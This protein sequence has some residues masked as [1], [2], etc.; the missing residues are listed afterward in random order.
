[1]NRLGLLLFVFTSVAAARHD[2]AVCGTTRETTPEALFRHR[3]SGRQF[4]PRAITQPA[5]RDIGNVAVIEDSGGVVEKLNQF[6]LDNSTVTFT[7][8]L[9]DASR[10]R[11]ATTG[12][13]FEDAA[14]S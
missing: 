2:I 12:Q 9:A 8:T 14:W 7:P 5:D 10:Y 1:M 6:N 4:R 11:Y 13:S 3:Q